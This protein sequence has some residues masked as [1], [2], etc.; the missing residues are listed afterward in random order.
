MPGLKDINID[1]LQKLTP[2]QK[3]AFLREINADILEMHKQQEKYFGITGPAPVMTEKQMID[4]ANDETR[5]K[6]YENSFSVGKDLR[7]TYI[8]DN[9]ANYK[10]PTCFARS[11]GY[12]FRRELEAEDVEYNQKLVKQLSTPEGVRKYMRD[13]ANKALALDETA[14]YKE[15]L[16]DKVN[17]FSDDPKFYQLLFEFYKIYKDAQNEFD[18]FTD[19]EMKQI[20][21]KLT[22]FQN[23]IVYDSEVRV[24][25]H[26]YHMVFPEMSPAL[27]TDLIAYYGEKG[28]TEKLDFVRL[29]HVSH[30]TKDS[31]RYG[32]TA[33]KILKENGFA[34]PTQTGVTYE[35]VDDK[36]VAF[37]GRGIG[38]EDLLNN[39]TDSLRITKTTKN[40]DEVVTHTFTL[41]KKMV[42]RRYAHDFLEKNHVAEDQR[43]AEVPFSDDPRIQDI[44]RAVIH[45]QLTTSNIQKGTAPDEVKQADFEKIVSNVLNGKD[46]IYKYLMSQPP[47]I[48]DQMMLDM[49]G[50]D[51]AAQSRF[52]KLYNAQH[53]DVEPMEY[54]QEP[55]SAFIN[56]ALAPKVDSSLARLVFPV[57]NNTYDFDEELIEAQAKIDGIELTIPN[58][59]TEEDVTALSFGYLFSKENL[60]A[61]YEK[62]KN[63]PGSNVLNTDP[64]SSGGSMIFASAFTDD[65]RANV[66]AARTFV[67]EARQK[68][69]DVLES[70]QRGDC[71]YQEVAETMKDSF[72]RL[73][74]Q[75]RYSSQQENSESLGAA[76]MLTS[77]SKV[78]EKPEFAKHITIT[79][80]QKEIVKL[81]EVQSKLARE[82]QEYGAKIS[83]RINEIQV[84]NQYLGKSNEISI[85]EDQELKNDFAEYN[86][87]KLYFARSSFTNSSYVNAARKVFGSLDKV[88]EAEY[89]RPLN[90]MQKNLLENPDKYIEYMKT[91]VTSNDYNPYQK[92]MEAKD[93]NGLTDAFIAGGTELGAQSF[94]LP[95]VEKW[96]IGKYVKDAMEVLEN[97]PEYKDLYNELKNLPCVTE[98]DDL[99][100]ITAEELERRVALYKDAANKI[101]ATELSI[102]KHV[103]D[104]DAADVV[105][106]FDAKDL[107]NDMLKAVNKMEGSID[108]AKQERSYEKGIIELANAKPEKTKEQHKEA[109][110][111]YLQNEKEAYEAE[112]AGLTTLRYGQPVQETYVE[113]IG[114]L[115]EN[116]EKNNIKDSLFDEAVSEL[117]NSLGSGAEGTEFVRLQESFDKIESELSE[118]ML[119]DDSDL[120][121]QKY[122]FITNLMSNMER[123][124]EAERL[125][126]EAQSKQSIYASAYDKAEYR[127][128][129]LGEAAEKVD[130]K[131]PEFK[132]LVELAKKSMENICKALSKIAYGH[133]Q[134]GFEMLRSG[135]DIATLAVHQTMVTAKDNSPI[136]GILETKGA[137]YFVEKTAQSDA[138]KNNCKNLGIEDVNRV[139]EDSRNLNE[140]LSNKAPEAK[141]AKG[142]QLYMKAPENVTQGP[143]LN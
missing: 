136:R 12:L 105:Q 30:A 81:A 44:Q 93:A 71:N 34:G 78:L 85:N 115:I 132:K 96:Q 48:A 4:L 91:Q 21:E 107:S 47:M 33:L 66:H 120:L 79:E 1:K 87:R 31:L 134:E 138:I 22:I 123:Y 77:L 127:A 39:A 90:R 99:R 49:V 108:L 117:K 52:F 62:M 103:G 65:N 137:E 70:I 94:N 50:N 102:G 126:P 121:R 97:M 63:I 100:E 125:T 2:E 109:Q 28:E 76:R 17:L 14:F 32:E 29:Y 26:P 37:S 16:E 42:V 59:Y 142:P 86:A 19:E 119:D 114:K 40:G 15:S 5:Q 3:L 139:L 133:E 122:A 106:T 124:E 23:A 57:G 69:A 58:G 24:V 53:R 56:S 25:G 75:Y 113:L 98:P 83:K 112:L 6:E 10:V 131:Y 68:T 27:A 43:L 88:E 38:V 54:A 11:K 110:E 8:K 118:R 73:V 89:T 7:G 141:D 61:S 101:G 135:R 128:Q 130:G 41:D 9:R 74:R 36:G 18:I 13:V 143:G 46:P 67:P 140:F 95:Y 51:K 84:E 111:Q 60:E 55:G 104:G 64:V 80:E 20:S 129:K 82:M 35:S 45:R 116:A 92:L 72:D